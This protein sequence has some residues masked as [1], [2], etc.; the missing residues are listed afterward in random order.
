MPLVQNNILQTT[1][2]IKIDE[3]VTCKDPNQQTV[4]LLPALGVQCRAIYPHVLLHYFCQTHP[5]HLKNDELKSTILNAFGMTIIDKYLK[6][7]YFL[8][9]KNM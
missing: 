8:M 7:L 4:D 3:K 2:E 5:F 1:I 6:R 9:L